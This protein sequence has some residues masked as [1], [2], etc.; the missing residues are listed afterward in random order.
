MKRMALGLWLGLCAMAA[1]LL[2]AATVNREPISSPAQ[3]DRRPVLFE[4]NNGQIDSRVRF[5]ARAADYALF[6][7]DDSATLAPTGKSALSIS[8]SGSRPGVRAEAVGAPVSRANYLRGSDASR[9]SLDVPLYERV[10]YRELYKG[11]DLL[12]HPSQWEMEYDFVLSPGADPAQIVLQFD[13]V[14]RLKLLQDGMLLAETGDS[15]VRQHVPL[16]Y[17]EKGGTR[18]RVSGGYRLLG[19]N[20]VGFAL[21]AYDRRLPLVIDPVFLYSSY[22]GGSGMDQAMAITVDLQ[23]NLYVTGATASLDFPVVGG[24][25]GSAGHSQ[26]VLGSTGYSVLMSSLPRSIRRVPRSCTPRT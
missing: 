8:F 14:Q 21:N 15:T 11:I 7:T 19:G 6:L 1:S 20:K 10:S 16:I 3:Y 24:I 18:H 23:G 4:Q 13:G 26:P 22:L 12:F 17:Q 25:P 5:V 9:W 2:N